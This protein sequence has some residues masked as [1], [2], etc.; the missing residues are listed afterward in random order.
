MEV[1]VMVNPDGSPVIEVDDIKESGCTEHT[2]AAVKALGGTEMIQW[3]Y[4]DGGRK[5]AGFKGSARD[6]F[7]RAVA[8]ATNI[9]YEQVYQKINEVAKGERP[10]GK[11][12]RSSARNG[13]H[14]YTSDRVMKAMGWEWVPTSKV[15][16]KEK[17]H[18]HP[19]ELPKGRIVARVSKHYVAVIDGVIHDTFDSARDGKRLVYG[20]WIKRFG[21]ASS[22]TSDTVD[23]QK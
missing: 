23:N 4:N 3:V 7:C 19:D 2:D 5:L 13:V 8:I 12:K 11:K 14:R 17:V 22:G 16:Q 20:Y 21:T 6:C 15:G 10:K 9:P 1:K 18:L